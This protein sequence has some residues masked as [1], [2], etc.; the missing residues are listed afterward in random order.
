MKNS[1]VII[2]VMKISMGCDGINLKRLHFLQF[3]VES[4]FFCKNKGRNRK[5]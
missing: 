2:E 4:V 3:F 1:V 5:K